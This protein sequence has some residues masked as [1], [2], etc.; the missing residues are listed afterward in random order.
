[1][2]LNL[3]SLGA[4]ARKGCPHG[5]QNLRSIPRH[6]HQA[7]KH[8]VRRPDPGSDGL[9]PGEL[10][11]PPG[12]A[13]AAHCSGPQKLSGHLRAECARAL[14]LARA[15]RQFARRD[16]TPQ[17]ISLKAVRPLGNLLGGAAQ[18]RYPPE[19]FLRGLVILNLRH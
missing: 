9:K 2:A 13:N 5:E 10:G 15:R 16:E 18:G 17:T 11:S 1:M 4:F 19:D 7:G 14:P 6:R 3:H 8:L 12:P